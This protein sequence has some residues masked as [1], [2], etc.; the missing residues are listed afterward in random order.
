MTSVLLLLAQAQAPHP[1]APPGSGKFQT[2]ENWLMWGAITICVVGLIVCGA[3]L[4]I[5]HRNGGGG[6]I[7]GQVGIVMAGCVL[8]GAAAPLI[9]ALL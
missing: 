4:A 3:K 6:G 9:N 1:V 5:E 7:G 8:I 2:V